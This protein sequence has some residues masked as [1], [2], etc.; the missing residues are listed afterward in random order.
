ML[1]KEFISKILDVNWRWC[2]FNHIYENEEQVPDNLLQRNVALWSIAPNS[3][4]VYI[5]VEDNSYEVNQMITLSTG[6]ISERTSNLLDDGSLNGIKIYKKEEYGWIIYLLDDSQYEKTIPEDLKTVIR[7]A[8]NKG[9]TVICFDRD[10]ETIDDLP[11][12]YW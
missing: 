12:F 10:A 8:W 1:V 2:I 9:F 5:T 6:H 4:I 11:V 3:N 7:F